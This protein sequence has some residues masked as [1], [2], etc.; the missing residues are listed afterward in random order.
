MNLANHHKEAIVRSIMND[1]P[2][3][4]SAKEKTDAQT[5][6]VKGMSQGCKTIYKRTPEALKTIYCRSE[7][8]NFGG[9]QQELIIGDSDYKTILAPFAKRNQDRKDIEKKVESAINSVKTRKQLIDRFPEFSIYAPEDNSPSKTLPAVINIV[10]DLVKVGWTQKVHK[11]T[12]K[13]K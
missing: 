1:I 13:I 12:V 10:S 2:Q 7:H 8:Y 3:A 5:A 6:L 9:W 4:D 11:G